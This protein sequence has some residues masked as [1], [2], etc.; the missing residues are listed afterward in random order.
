MWSGVLAQAR[1]EVWSPEGSGVHGEVNAFDTGKGTLFEVQL[2]GLRPGLHGFHIHRGGD[3][4]SGCD[5]PGVCA[6]FNPFGEEHGGL[7]AVPSHV[8]DLG[9]VMADASGNVRQSILARRVSLLGPYSVLHRTLVVHAGRD[10]LGFG[11]S[12]DSKTTGDSGARLACGVLLPVQ[13][14]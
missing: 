3:M 5:G 14:S 7:N 9:N 11:N 2:H 12:P 10:D 13:R 8:G 6:H 4:S 1:A